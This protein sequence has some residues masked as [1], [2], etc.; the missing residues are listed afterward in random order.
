MECKS[1]CATQQK[2]R[3]R[4]ED[5]KKNSRTSALEEKEFCQQEIKRVLGKIRPVVTKKS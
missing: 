2:E 1:P 5:K 4:D 3:R